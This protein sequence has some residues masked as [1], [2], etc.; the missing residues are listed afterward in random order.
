MGSGD[1]NECVE[2]SFV[3]FVDEFGF[4]SGEFVGVVFDVDADGTVAFATEGD[5]GAGAAVREGERG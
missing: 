5:A 4:Y 3:G 1:G 2:G